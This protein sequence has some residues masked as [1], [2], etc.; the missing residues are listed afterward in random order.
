MSESLVIL[1]LGL[2]SGW[3]SS[4]ELSVSCLPEALYKDILGHTNM[5]DAVYE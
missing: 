1:K 3:I 2:M 5:M 4:R